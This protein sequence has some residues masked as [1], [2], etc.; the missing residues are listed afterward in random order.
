LLARRYDFLFTTHIYTNALVS[1]MRRMGL[2]RAGRLAM[3]ESMALFDRFGGLKA[4]VF[5][6]LYRWYGGEDLL[7][8]QTPY[9]ADHVR[10]WLRPRSAAHLHAFPNPVDVRTIERA[11]AEGLDPSLRERLAERPAI[12]FCGR[13]VP[14]KRPDLALEAFRLLRSEQPRAQ[15]VFMG[16]GPLEASVRAESARSGL[17]DS[18]LFLGQRANPYPVMAACRY[19]LVT[20]DNE[21]FPNALLEMMACGMEAIVTTPCADGLEELPCVKVIETHE[22]SDLATALGSALESPD[23]CAERYRAAA[24]ARSAKSYVDLLL[25]TRSP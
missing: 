25:A 1:A 24:A 20:S 2:V 13:F 18:V 4:K 7:I 22:A 16:T 5:R 19:G 9:M 17:A 12:L 11:I 10:P 6:R 14:F 23:S 8:A 3:R 15:L 21:G